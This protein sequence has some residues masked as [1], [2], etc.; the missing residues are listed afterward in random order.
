MSDLNRCDFTGHLGADPTLRYTDGGTAIAN[1][2][3]AASETFTKDGNKEEKT[4][5][6]SCVAFKKTAEIIGEHL[7]K[8]SFVRVSGRMQTRKWTD[9]DGN[10]RWT[11]EIVLRE[12]QFL[13]KKGSQAPADVHDAPADDGDVPF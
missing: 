6:I 1:F 11:T 12:M 3:I 2:R 13:D 9:K 5:W 10:D 7:K 4:E 8:G